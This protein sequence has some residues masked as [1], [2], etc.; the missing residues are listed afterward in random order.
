MKFTFP[1]EAIVADYFNE[2]ITKSNKLN[3]RDYLYYMGC[4]AANK[5]AASFSSGVNLKVVCAAEDVDFY[6]RGFVETLRV[7][8]PVFYAARWMQKLSHVIPNLGDLYLIRHTYDEPMP[9]APY[10]LIYLKPFFISQAEARSCLL[11]EIDEGNPTKIHV[12]TIYA[13]SMSY[14]AMRAE[15]PEAIAD[16]MTIFSFVE[17]GGIEDTIRSEF[18]E[19]VKDFY[20]SMGFDCSSGSPKGYLPSLILEKIQ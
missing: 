18:C 20:G 12:V 3:A 6:S 14:E 11:N 7:N 9:E 16:S 1:E 19:I 2:L 17:S 10:E 5:L 13:D 4:K 15:F 8:F